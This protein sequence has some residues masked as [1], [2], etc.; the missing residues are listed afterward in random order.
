M[1]ISKINEHLQAYNI[2]QLRLQKD[3]EL[4]VR[5][6][7]EKKAVQRLEE[8]RTERAKRLDLNIGRNIDI[9]C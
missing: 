2:A 8:K 1:K 6:T 7:A 9:D 4:I 5:R 3:R